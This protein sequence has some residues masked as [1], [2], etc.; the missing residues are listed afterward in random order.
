[1]RAHL[2][3]N[4]NTVRLAGPNLSPISTQP[5][6][7]E[8]LQIP[9]VVSKYSQ[10]YLHGELT[11]K[12]YAI[13]T[14]N[15][16]K[17][18]NEYNLSNLVKAKVKK[19]KE[20]TEGDE[21]Y[22]YTTVVEQTN[23]IYADFI[24]QPSPSNSITI[25]EQVRQYINRIYA[26]DASG[27]VNP[28]R[29]P[30]NKIC[31]FV[32]KHSDE[33]LEFFRPFNASEARIHAYFF[34]YLADS[35]LTSTVFQNQNNTNKKQIVRSTLIHIFN[36]I[37]LMSDDMASKIVQGVNYVEDPIAPTLIPYDRNTFQILL[38]VRAVVS[39]GFKVNAILISEVKRMDVFMSRLATSVEDN[40]FLVEY[41]KLLRKGRKSK[42]ILAY[43]SLITYLVFFGVAAGMGYLLYWSRNA[44]TTLNNAVANTNQQINDTCI[45]RGE[46]A[47]A[48]ESGKESCDIYYDEPALNILKCCFSV[49]NCN[50]AVNVLLNTLKD[51]CNLYDKY[52]NINFD[53]YEAL[54]IGMISVVALVL[55]L[56]AM[57]IILKSFYLEV[58]PHDSLD[59]YKANIIQL[60]DS[61]DEF[62]SRQGIDILPIERFVNQPSA[63]AAS[64]ICKVIDPILKAGDEQF[65]YDAPV[66]NAVSLDMGFSLNNAEENQPL[67]PRAPASLRMGYVINQ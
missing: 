13:F 5:G 60:F 15:L 57:A 17:R 48:A 10:Q 46:W 63:D 28:L 41:K 22:R 9:G 38:D 30:G 8:Y 42:K 7:K 11:P 53:T 50:D 12:Q 31:D 51:L 35:I 66:P 59:D 43:R 6:L 56:A 55:S 34:D 49:E 14:H 16:F 37:S 29:I 65:V 2:A 25:D 27:G 39:L 4:P 62:L 21:R 24:L 33:F 61:V 40:N 52:E 19:L 26:N 64:Q 1:M 3:P 67:L 54:A 23:K 32:Q 20:I 18:L 45:P 47:P 58:I 36:T 44:E